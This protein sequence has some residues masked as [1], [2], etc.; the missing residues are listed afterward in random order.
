MQDLIILELIIAAVLFLAIIRP[1][2]KRFQGIEGIAALPTIAL[3][4]AIAVFPAYGFRPEFMPLLAFSLILF[5]GSIPRLL[6][7]LRRLRTD[8][9]GERSFIRLAFGLLALGTVSVFAVMYAPKSERIEE[10]GYRVALI[11]DEARDVDLSLRYFAPATDGTGASR[12]PFI[13]IAPPLSGSVSVMTRLCAALTER[14]FSAATFSHV[15]ADIPAYLPDGARAYPSGRTFLAGAGAFVWGR[16]Y[17]VANRAG[18]AIERERAADIAF[19]VKHVR[20]A[21]VREDPPYGA[22]DIDRIVVAG[23]GSGGAAATI[24]AASSEAA[25]IAAAVAVEGPILSALR[26]EGNGS[27]TPHAEAA[28]SIPPAIAELFARFKVERIVGTGSVPAPTVPTLF[29]VSDRVAEPADR[30]GR[31]VTVLRALRT[32]KVPCA[33]ASVDGA[34][35]LDYSDIGQEYPLYAAM[36]PGL[37]RQPRAPGF[38]VMKAADL[39]ANFVAVTV[40]QVEGTPRLTRTA[41]GE[42]F[43][44]EA[45]GSWTAADIA[46]ILRP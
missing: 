16:R 28:G 38:F 14:G 42:E 9:Y 5:L 40:P 34:G 32:A 41:L 17:A 45:G 43:R 3:V 13:L 25:S 10:S 6:D 4:A 22:I 44:V 23:F 20:D 18:S 46:A 24:Y 36:M 15:G 11:H 30:D 37:K 39:I 21:A 35:P 33:L 12:R 2:V 27:A 1:F 29:L 8:D 7:V 19:I 26:S 31:Y